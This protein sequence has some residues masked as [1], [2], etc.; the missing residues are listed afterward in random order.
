VVD[1]HIIHA[2]LCHLKVISISAKNET[3]RGNTRIPSTLTVQRR[4][5]LEK[6]SIYAVL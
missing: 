4:T 3:H 6:P 1:T 5:V 2:M